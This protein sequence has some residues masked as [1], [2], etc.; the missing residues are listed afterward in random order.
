MSYFKSGGDNKQRLNYSA[1]KE[2]LKRNLTQL[3]INEKHFS[4]HCFRHAGASTAS[5]AGMPSQIFKKH[6]RW[7]S[8]SGDGYVHDSLKQKLRVAEA[9]RSKLGG[10]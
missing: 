4:W 6:G 3:D 10:L 7:K 1:A 5:N 8:A 9:L 2:D